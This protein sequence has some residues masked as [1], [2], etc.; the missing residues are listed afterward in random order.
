MVLSIRE[1]TPAHNA[2]KIGVSK[3]QHVFYTG[4][5]ILSRQP[6]ANL[7]VF[8][9]GWFKCCSKIRIPA[10]ITALFTWSTESGT[11]SVDTS[12][13]RSL[14]SDWP[15]LTDAVTTNQEVD[16]LTPYYL[17]GG[18][19]NKWVRIHVRVHISTG[20]KCTWLG[21]SFVVDIIQV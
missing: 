13:A 11:S 12:L 6:T 20:C 2:C 14:Q 4:D 8:S 19:S 17:I 5:I 3:V 18:S 16:A 9:D 21:V 1:E 10:L 15:T 7:M